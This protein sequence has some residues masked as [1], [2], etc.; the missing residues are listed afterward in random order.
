[1]RDNF[2]EQP[3]QKPENFA[4]HIDAIAFK[5]R[6]GIKKWW[7]RTNDPK[8]IRRKMRQ[9]EPS[10]QQRLKDVFVLAVAFAICLI[11]TLS[12]SID[13]YKAGETATWLLYTFGAAISFI[14]LGGAISYS[15]AIATSKAARIR[16]ERQVQ[17]AF[18][19]FT[20]NLGR[21]L[22]R[23][24][25]LALTVVAISVA[26][27][28]V[29]GLGDHVPLVAEASQQ[30]IDIFNTMLEKAVAFFESHIA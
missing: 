6:D 12:A 16:F 18:D 15:E 26:L 23:I 20:E 25:A 3:K 30:V 10:V 22:R 4:D 21:L 14:C 7:R 8:A 29:P 1:M 11:F 24:V 28:Y 5:M 2:T 9:N 19:N 27:Q 13:S 17:R